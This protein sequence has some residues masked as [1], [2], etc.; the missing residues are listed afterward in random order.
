MSADG[1]AP[2][3]TTKK[4]PGGSKLGAFYRV[5]RMLHAY[6]SAFAFLALIFFSV[7]GVLLNHPDWFAQPRPSAANVAITLPRADMEAALR[8]SDPARALTA[9]AG[10]E[11][12]LR[13]EYK[14]GDVIDGEALIHMEGATGTTD[15]AIDLTTGKAEV[16]VQPKDAVTILH[17]LH[18]GTNT[19]AAWRALID[20]TAYLVLALS[21]IGYILFFSLRFRLRTSLALTFASLA[22]MGAVFYFLVP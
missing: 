16:T 3:T 21:L 15:L 17:E 1:A 9:L 14:S 5:N 6:F 20:I 13:G 12:R 4:K 22:A 10:E 7:T 18:R 19:G 11:T 8:A 2:V